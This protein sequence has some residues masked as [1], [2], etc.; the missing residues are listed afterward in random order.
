MADDACSLRN[1]AYAVFK[2]DI[3]NIAYKV[4]VTVSFKQLQNG[5]YRVDLSGRK[6]HVSFMYNFVSTLNN[7]GF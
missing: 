7:I 3:I 1:G 2:D 6:Q 5:R 4:N